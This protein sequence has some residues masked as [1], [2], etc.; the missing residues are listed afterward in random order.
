[1]IAWNCW[2]IKQ[3]TCKETPSVSESKLVVS[4]ALYGGEMLSLRM[5]FKWNVFDL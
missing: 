1:V 3:L 2:L 4:E 5:L